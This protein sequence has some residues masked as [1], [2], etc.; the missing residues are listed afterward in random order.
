MLKLNFSPFPVLTTERLVLDELSFDDVPELFTLRTDESVNKYLDRLKARS[1]DDVQKFIK[2]IHSSTRNN[3]ALFW[4]IHFKTGSRLVGTVCLWNISVPHKTAEIGYELLPDFQ[5]KG[6]MQEAL[7]KVIE[8]SFDT[9]KVEALEAIA[10]MKNERSTLLL[11]KFGF[12]R[13]SEKERELV[14]VEKLEDMHAYALNSKTF[15]A[16]R[17]P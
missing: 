17:Q 16:A 9:I 13:S 5:G 15:F 7:Q 1:I 11:K 8:Y 4:G 2:K 12:D 14:E 3:E 10:H 6:I